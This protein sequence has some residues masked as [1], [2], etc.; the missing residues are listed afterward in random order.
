MNNGVSKCT[1]SYDKY[2]AE[3]VKSSR[4]VVL[5]VHLPA[6]YTF[7]SFQT[8][9]TQYELARGFAIT[10]TKLKTFELS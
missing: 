1:M 6:V 9:I 3:L 5:L 7:N 8:I 4:N 2:T 10:R